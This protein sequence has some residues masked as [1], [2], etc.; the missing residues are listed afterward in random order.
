MSHGGEI[1]AVNNPDGGATFSF[2][3]PFDDGVRPCMNVSVEQSELAF[4]KEGV[5]G[6]QRAGIFLAPF[7]SWGLIRWCFPG[8]KGHSQAR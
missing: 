6:R 5:I 8:C 7:N 2:T 1:R 3:V 4:T